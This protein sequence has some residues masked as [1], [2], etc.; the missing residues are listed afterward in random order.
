MHDPTPKWIIKKKKERKKTV[1]ACAGE[2]DITL[3]S[4]CTGTD[5]KDT[6]VMCRAI[7]TTDLWSGSCISLR[8]GN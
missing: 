2:W 1:F 7:V 4:N 6:Q 5:C 3:E 8:Q